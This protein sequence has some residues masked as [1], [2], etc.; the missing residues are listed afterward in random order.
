MIPREVIVDV[1]Q[2]SDAIQVDL[3]RLESILAG[4]SKEAQ[5]EAA[6]APVEDILIAP[7]DPA[8]DLALELG[9]EEEEAAEN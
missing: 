8:T 4:I 6:D 7:A 9:D 2:T 3:P 5:A 1:F